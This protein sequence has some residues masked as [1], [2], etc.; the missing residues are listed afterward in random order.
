[1]AGVLDEFGPGRARRNETPTPETIEVGLR[2]RHGRRQAGLSQRD[3]EDRSGI[4][5]SEISRLE[6][7]KTPGMSAYRV[8]A[9]ALALGDR[10]PFGVCPHPHRC[11]YSAETLTTAGTQVGVIHLSDAADLVPEEEAS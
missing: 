7:G 9:I 4:S 8:F 3:V 11:A 10:F 1:M 5:Q 6:R 2:F